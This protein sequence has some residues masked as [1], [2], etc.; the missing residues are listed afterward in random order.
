[1]AYRLLLRSQLSQQFGL[2]LPRAPRQL[3]QDVCV[4]MYSESFLCRFRAASTPP[5]SVL[6]SE[7]HSTKRVS[8]L[9]LLFESFF[10]P[11]LSLWKSCPL[12]FLDQGIEFTPISPLSSDFLG[13]FSP[14]FSPEETPQL[15]AN[16]S[17]GTSQHNFI[18]GS[19]SALI[20]YSPQQ[21]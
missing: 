3:A 10:L 1:M 21:I 9:R 17:P 20:D 4:F 18:L 2:S 15:F 11:T 16:P 6:S 19:R 8:L 12:G 5:P 13:T 14:P 7:G